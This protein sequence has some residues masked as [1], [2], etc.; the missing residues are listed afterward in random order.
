M[1]SPLP[2]MPNKEALASNIHYLNLIRIQTISPQVPR[3]TGQNR[4]FVDTS[5]PAMSGERD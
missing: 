3:W 2:R 5:K 4:P 1:F